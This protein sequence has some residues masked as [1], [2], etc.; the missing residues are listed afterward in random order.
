MLV[1]A[2]L[3]FWGFTWGSRLVV[4]ISG[5]NI[6]IISA[7]STNSECEGMT[8]T[9]KQFLP[10]LFLHSACACFVFTVCSVVIPC[11][12]DRGLYFGKQAGLQSQPQSNEVIRINHVCASTTKV[13]YAGSICN[14]L[15]TKTESR[16]GTATP[17]L[18][19]SHAELS[20]GSAQTCQPTM[21][22]GL[23]M[24]SHCAQQFCRNSPKL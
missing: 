24:C 14:L 7:H 6:L 3:T 19:F 17:E 1:P 16:E 11:S 13:Q 23:L 2:V 8:V 21:K 22:T 5:T 10:D 15:S 4:S 20:Y 18:S 9:T 12:E